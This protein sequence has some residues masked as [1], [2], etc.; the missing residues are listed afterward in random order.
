LLVEQGLVGLAVWALALAAAL[1]RVVWGAA[2]NRT[3]A[4]ALAAAMV[5]VLVVGAVDSLLDM[6][7]VALLLTLLTG[8]ALTLPVS[9]RGGDGD[10]VQLGL[11]TRSADSRQS[12]HL[13]RHSRLDSSRH[14]HSSR[15]SGR[16]G[17]PDR[18]G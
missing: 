7:R 4:S 17:R 5:G 15:R 6:P 9:R 11:D 12:T 18:H 14:S 1:W 2:S 13:S 8:L 3:L 10:S 16:S